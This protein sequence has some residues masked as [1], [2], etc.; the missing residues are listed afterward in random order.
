MADNINN[1]MNRGSKYDWDFQ[2][3]NFAIFKK[4]TKRALIYSCWVREWDIKYQSFERHDSSSQSERYENSEQNKT[5]PNKARFRPF[6]TKLWY[7]PVVFM[8]HNITTWKNNSTVQ[9]VS[10]KNENLHNHHHIFLKQNLDFGLLNE[11]FQVTTGDRVVKDM[12]VSYR[13]LFEKSSR[14]WC[15]K[16]MSL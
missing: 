13:T 2:N 16:S 3:D 4:E 7:L 11:S 8:F 5:V 14:W 6:L 1:N 15:W 9:L 12:Q 10:P